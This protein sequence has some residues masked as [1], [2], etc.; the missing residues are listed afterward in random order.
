VIKKLHLNREERRA[1]ARRR[2]EVDKERRLKLIREIAK[3][4]QLL[5]AAKADEKNDG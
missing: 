5:R 4:Q 2:A 3:K 1:D